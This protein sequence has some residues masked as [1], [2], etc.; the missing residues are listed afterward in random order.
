MIRFSRTTITY[1]DY[2]KEVTPFE[3]VSPL[4]KLFIKS[5][6]RAPADCFEA[7][8]Y[9]I[10]YFRRLLKNSFYILNYFYLGGVLM[11]LRKKK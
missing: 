8:P 5:K 3:K 7:P 1:K 10:Q 2:S 9:F 6:L 11:Y 4:K